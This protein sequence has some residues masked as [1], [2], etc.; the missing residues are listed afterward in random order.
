MLNTEPRAVAARYDR[1]SGQVVIDLMNGCTYAFPAKL[2][3]DV[4]GASDDDLAGVEVDGMGFKLHWPA[5]NV[6]LLT[7]ALVSGHFGT[8]TWMTRE[9]TRRQPIRP[10]GPSHFEEMFGYFYRPRH[11]QWIQYPRPQRQLFSNP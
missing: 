10:Y 1:A 3:Q 2:V 5:L 11:L 6:D 8:R 9:G 4:Q 7:P